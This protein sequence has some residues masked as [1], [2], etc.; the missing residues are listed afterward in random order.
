MCIVATLFCLCGLPVI[1][2]EA[3]P[4]PCLI[5]SLPLT[6]GNLYLADTVRTLSLRD[7]NSSDK[8]RNLSLLVL[9]SNED[10]S[11]IVNIL[12]QTYEANEC[13]TTEHEFRAQPQCCGIFGV[14]GDINFETASILHTIASRSNL[15]IR[16]GA[17]MQVIHFL[18]PVHTVT[19]CCISYMQLLLVQII[20]L[21]RYIIIASYV[22]NE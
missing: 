2:V 19:I 14:V 1:S 9:N 3:H 6:G 11:I 12:S 8:I 7:Q 18:T 16:L 5:L 4:A 22:S 10:Y 21:H 20:T 17:E 13:A 15:T